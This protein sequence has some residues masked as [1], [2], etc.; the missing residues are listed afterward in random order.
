MTK[1]KNVFVPPDTRIGRMVDETIGIDNEEAWSEPNSIIR[2]LMANKTLDR[3]VLPRWCHYFHHNE[4][5]HNDTQHN[6]LGNSWQK[7][8]DRLAELKGI[9]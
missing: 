9:W 7:A 4:I 8:L 2:Q 5:T 1:K 6:I 3:L